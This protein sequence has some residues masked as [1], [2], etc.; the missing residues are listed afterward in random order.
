LTNSITLIV[1]VGYDI[2]VNKLNL[3]KPI[4]HS[5]RMEQQWIRMQAVKMVQTG[6]SATEVAEFFEV[7]PRAVFKWL[8]SFAESG[9]NGLVAK[10]GAGRPP[11]VNADQMRW[12]AWTVRDSTP[13]Q[14]RFEFG[15]WT[16][17]L[18]GQ[19]FARQFGMSLSKPTL[20][21]IMKQLG[22]TPQRPLHRAYEQDAVLVQRWLDTD[23][24]ALR[25]RAKARGARILF[26][27][28]ASMRGDYHA[29]T[30]WAPQ[31]QTPIVKATG[32]RP[33]VNMISAVSS[34]GELQFMLVQGSTN[35]QVFK[36]FLQQ[37]MI[38]ATQPIILVVDGH[39]IHKAGLV[40]EYVASTDG[41]L[42]LYYLPPYSPQLNPDEQVWKN[43]KARVAK[44][45][46]KDKYE[47]RIMLHKALEKLQSLPH[48]VR[49]FF[50]H[51]ECGFVN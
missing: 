12:I 1:F 31:G 13:N 39:S 35:A 30:T 36:Q 9:Q 44:Q 17:A 47:L 2:G 29:G 24:P 4:F 22:F 20:S 34:L 26:A 6:Y 38:G 5:P 23:L 33:T 28:E 16:L 8:A 37:L 51:P 49:G 41:M 10:D 21:K 48:I 43:I 15:L 27:D 19:V 40:K 46:P 42:E 14:Y 7:T 50:A 3:Q 32:Q 18:I 25:Q 45:F 11:K